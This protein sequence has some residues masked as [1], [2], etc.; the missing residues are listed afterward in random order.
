MIMILMNK[1]H[2]N[3]IIIEIASYDDN[4]Y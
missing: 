1:D 2:K 4:F 3:K